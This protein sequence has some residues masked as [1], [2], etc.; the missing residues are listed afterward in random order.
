ML[1]LDNVQCGGNA[2]V[3]DAIIPAF[4]SGLVDVLK[5]GIPIILV[6]LC[7]LDLGKAVM[8][9]DEKEMKGAQGKLIKRCI[10]AVL[11]F[12]IVA[13]VQFVFGLLSRSGESDYTGCIDCFL[14]N[15]CD[16]VKPSS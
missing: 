7:M 8:S 10:Y 9:N 14:N 15:N 1:I 12:F 4:V 5:F 13:I 16:D 6:I 11:V 3:I 2:I